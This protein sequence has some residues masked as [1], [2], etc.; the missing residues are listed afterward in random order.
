MPGIVFAS[1]AFAADGA[2]ELPGIDPDKDVEV[3][4][5]DR[6]LTMTAHRS[7]ATKNPHRSKFYYG[8]MTRAVTLCAASR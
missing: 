6:V 1:D 4:A 7:Q 5:A 2:T 8:Q 3:T